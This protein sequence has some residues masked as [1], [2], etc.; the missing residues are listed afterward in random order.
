M[1]KLTKTEQ[2][3]LFLPI[4]CVV[5]SLISIFG[6]LT[7]SLSSDWLRILLILN[8]CAILLLLALLAVF[9]RRQIVSANSASEFEHQAYTDAMTQVKNRAAFQLITKK[10]I[11]SEYPKLTLIMADLNNLKQV[12]DTLGHTVGD[13][14]I[15][16][17]ASYLEQ[18]FG[19]MGHIYRWG[20]DEFMVMIEDR[21]PAEIS[22]AQ[23]RFTTLI[24]DHRKHGGFEISAAIGAASRMDPQNATLDVFELLRMAD[25]AMYQ[26]KTTQKAKSGTFQAA[27]HHW[28]EQIDASTGIYSFSAFKTRLYDSLAFRSTQFPCI[29]NFDLNCF[30]G[31][32]DIYGWDA[33]NQLLQKLTTLAMNLCGE[34]GFCAHSEGDS[35]WVFADQPSLEALI[36]RITEETRNFQDQLDSLLV[37]PSFGIYCVNDHM[38]PVSD[39]C[40]RATVAK[41][42]IKG[43]LNTLYN[44]YGSEDRQRRTD[45]LKLTSHM[46]RRLDAESMPLGYQPIYAA[47]GE[48]IIGAEAMARWQQADDAPAPIQELISI[49]RASGLILALDWYILNKVCNFLRR[50]LDNGVRCVPVSVNFSEQHMEDADFTERL[51]RTVDHQQIPRQLIRVE[52]PALA[53]EQ[54]PD[55]A[56]ALLRAMD[57]MGFSIL[58]DDFAA[59]PATLKALPTLAADAVKLDPAFMDFVELI[60]DHK[61]ISTLFIEKCRANSLSVIANGIANEKQTEFLRKCGC[62]GLQ[63]TLLSGFIAEEEFESMLQRSQQSI[64]KMPLPAKRNKKSF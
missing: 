19:R 4:L 59:R 42:S 64:A 2:Y 41:R 10:L 8:V 31:Y 36:Q 25:L 6:A 28:L 1:S 49:A 24:A 32:N 37:F 62:E 52:I 60:D 47:D 63:G 9:I 38:A 57:E 53:L 39:M 17:L 11:P 40:S 14:L 50:Q 5:L 29:V 56:P 58:I 3:F 23:E 7:R 43:R 55:R 21:S 20:G 27:T 44:V 34:N 30:D 61:D 48:S 16:L 33:G 45:W 35:F 12:N 15:C 46:Q 26:Y 51:R 18:A 54:H 22:A 13:K